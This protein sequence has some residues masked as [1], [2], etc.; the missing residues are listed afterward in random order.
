[1]VPRESKEKYSWAGSSFSSRIDFGNIWPT[2][3]P[4]GHLDV[5]I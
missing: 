5:A 4:Y 2:A 3:G 1:M